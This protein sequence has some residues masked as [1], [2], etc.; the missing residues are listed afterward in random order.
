MNVA[1]NE[2]QIDSLQEVVNIAMG[3]A[4]SSLAQ[5]FDSFVDLSIP[6]IKI[7][8]AHDINEKFQCLQNSK[9]DCQ[10]VRQAF[11]NGVSG[12]SIV[13]YRDTEFA[14]LAELIGLQG[15]EDDEIMF[16]INN[17]LVGATLC[18]IADQLN[19]DIGF[20]PPAK[21]KQTDKETNYPAQL[22]WNKALYIEI[23]FQFETNNFYCNMLLLM[24]EDSLLVLKQKIEDLMNNL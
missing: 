14:K 10:A 22:G 5:L 20:N 19:M 2:S 11:F 3:Q 16:D 12:E 7:F 6:Y 8:D 9:F 15:L 23:S 18:G 17:I 4:A 13:I 21:L 1:Y 24:S